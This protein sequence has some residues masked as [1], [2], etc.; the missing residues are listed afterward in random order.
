MFR[1]LDEAEW[2]AF[3]YNNKMGN[4]VKLKHALLGP[5]LCFGFIHRLSKKIS[6]FISNCSLAYN[7]LGRVM[8][9]KA[10]HWQT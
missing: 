4:S 6:K 9:I 7:S 5:V 8:E 10:K 1:F 3:Y 2:V